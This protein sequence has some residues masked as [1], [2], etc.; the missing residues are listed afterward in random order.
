MKAIQKPSVSAEIAYLKCSSAA[1]GTTAETLC[2]LAPRA[3]QAAS[4]YA[5]AATNG[6]VASLDPADF[7]ISEALDI[8]LRN[9]YSSRMV[10]SRSA[11]REVYDQI[12]MMSD[13]CVLCETT[14][15]SEVDHYLPKKHFPLLSVAPDN[16]LPVCH[17]CN[18]TK[19]EYRPDETRAALLNPYF[20]SFL[21]E[22]WLTATVSQ[23]TRSID[24][25]VSPPHSWPVARTERVSAHF[26]KLGLGWRFAAMAGSMLSSVRGQ[27]ACFPDANRATF[28]GSMADYTERDLGRN[29]WQPLTYRA[30]GASDWYLEEGYQQM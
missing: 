1:A 24:F 17:L 29:H 2:G 4:E 21:D 9:N 10:P 3:V 16:L 6:T 27:F 22:A 25:S 23:R 18:R 30:L 11:A 15:V 19:S 13:F 7:S 8:Q 14:I 28:L 5:T 12:R 20:D 26:D